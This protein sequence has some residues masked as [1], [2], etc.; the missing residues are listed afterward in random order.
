MRELDVETLARVEDQLHANCPSP[1]EHLVRLGR[2]VAILPDSERAAILRRLTLDIDDLTAQTRWHLGQAL[3]LMETQS[4]ILGTGEDADEFIGRFGMETAAQLLLRGYIRDADRVLYSDLSTPRRGGTVGGWIFHMMVD[5][6]VYRAVAALDRLATILW[7]AAELPMERVYFRSR[8]VRK[9]HGAIST[10]ETEELLKIAEGEL[11]NFIIDYRD[12]L[13]HRIKAYSK[14]AG[15]LPSDL[16]ETED[17]KL[18]AWDSEKWDAELLFALGRASYLQFTD[19]LG[20]GTNIC[21]RKWPI[22]SP[23]R[24][25]GQA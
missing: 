20:Y 1:E 13:T 17:G 3:L 21:E 11:F 7:Y 8:K 12:G 24:D 25:G 4:E 16:W 2:S 15:T 5:S 9:L 14:P 6:A 22:R 19:A 23:L 18:V 10:K